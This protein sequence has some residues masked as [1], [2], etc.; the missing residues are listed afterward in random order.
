MTHAD[1]GGDNLEDE[2][3][4]APA[5]EEL[6]ML[7]TL[8][9]D[10]NTRKRL[11]GKKGEALRE[12][13]EI[14][15]QIANESLSPTERVRLGNRLG[16]LNGTSFSGPGP[17]G[18]GQ[19]VWRPNRRPK[20]APSKTVDAELDCRLIQRAKEL[21][22]LKNT[23]GAALRAAIEEA[24]KEGK[25]GEVETESQIKRLR[26]KAGRLGLLTG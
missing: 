21:L 19:F 18:V 1:N 14:R 10:A 3:I 5:V 4:D 8:L 17:L 24:R 26:R 7:A 2:D 20:G 25:F 11:K 16:A 12:L 13:S 6:R 9:W 15:A 23:I 22:P